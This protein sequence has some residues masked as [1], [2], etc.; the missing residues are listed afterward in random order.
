M[1]I[2]DLRIGLV[3]SGGGAKGAYQIGVLEALHETGLATEVVAVS[4]SS[5]GAIVGFMFSFSDVSS[6]EE[7][8]LS[9]I[10]NRSFWTVNSANARRVVLPT[11]LKQIS[12]MVNEDI[13]SRGLIADD[14]LRSL[15]G[16]AYSARKD[17][18]LNIPCFATAWDF[19]ED[20]PARLRIDPDLFFED[21]CMS[22][23][24]S[25]ASFPPFFYPVKVGRR[26]YFD[27]GCIDNIPIKPVLDYQPDLIIVVNIEGEA[28][29]LG[30]SF[31]GVPL[32]EIRPFVPLGGNSAAMDFDNTAPNQLISQGKEEGLKYLQTLIT[33]IET[34]GSI[35][36]AASATTVRFAH[37]YDSYNQHPFSLLG[38]KAFCEAVRAFYLAG[39]RRNIKFPTFGGI[40]FWDD[41][42]YESGWR[43]Q[44]HKGTM[45]CRILDPDDF[46]VS[47]G[48]E[49]SQTYEFY[50]RFGDSLYLDF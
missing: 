31:E 43:L 13:T 27:G 24:Q 4:G 22:A 16:K 26:H 40:H 41:I 29:R 28:S 33:G 18:C 35:Q 34:E 37:V 47:W 14:G 36:S 8:W 25:S 21:T 48:S 49:V 39:N 9:N 44:Q 45:Y 20:K 5:I 19:M 38:E 30:N 6:A 3:L 46:R 11:V 15:I 17:D 7:I 2:S 10:D 1:R 12:N 42:D 32:F 50:K 23:L